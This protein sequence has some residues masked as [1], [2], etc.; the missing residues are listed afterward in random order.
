[1]INQKHIEIMVNKVFDSVKRYEF[2][3]YRKLSDAL[4]AEVFETTE[5]LYSPPENGYKPIKPGEYWGQE[6]GYGWFRLIYTVPE[7]LDGREIY[8]TQDTGAI[9]CLVFIN[10]KCCG[11]FDNTADYPEEQRLH[12]TKLLTKSAKAGET[13]EIVLEA[14]S[15]HLRSGC[16]PFEISESEASRYNREYRG[17]TILELNHTVYD[18]LLN[19]RLV[20]QL[21][22]TLPQDSFQKGKIAGILE[23]VFAVLSQD[24]AA[25]IDSA[26]VL[27]EVD[28]ANEL[29][30]PLLLDKNGDNAAFAGLIGHSHL[31]TVWLWPMEETVHK[32]ARTFS[33][34]LAMME[35]YPEY[36][37]IASSPFHYEWIKNH[38]PEMFERIKQRVA[39]GRWEPNGGS[40]V[41]TDCN[42]TG[43]E[44]LIRQFVK[45]QRFTR[46]NFNYTADTFWLP[47]TFGY[48]ASI[49]QIM[50]GCGMK[51]FVT[52]K[53]Y[54][55]DTVDFPYDTFIWRGVDG[56]EVLS[57][58][59]LIHIWPD[60]FDVKRGVYY[61]S[62]HKK[63]TDRK[64]L[65]Y[66]LGDGG[67]GPCKEMID[68]SR[69]VS[70]LCGMPKTEHT[71][72]SR[73]LNELA[74]SVKDI[75]LY[76]GELYYEY[77]RGTLTSMAKIKYLNRHIEFALRNLEIVSVLS[78]K[79]NGA[80]RPKCIEKLYDK[81]Y[82]NQFHDILPGSSIERVN[83]RAIAEMSEVLEGANRNIS[84]IFA[85]LITESSDITLYNTLSWNRNDVINLDGEICF[86]DVLT[87]TYTDIDGN[88]KTAV[89]GVEIPA[90]SAVTL[91]SGKFVSAENSPFTVNGNTVTTPYAKVEFNSNGEIVSLIDTKSRRELRDKN[92]FPL[93]TFI[94]GEDLPSAWD[95]WNNDADQKLKMRNCVKLISKEIV[96]NGAVELRIRNKY[97]VPYNSTL[98]Q[99]IVFY[100]NSPKIDFETV[101]DWNEKHRLLKTAF[102][103]DLIT[104]YYKSEIQYGYLERASFRD[105]NPYEQARFEVCNHK[106]SDMSESRFGVALLNDSKYGV[107]VDG[108]SMMITL[109][110]SGTHPDTRGDNGVHRF[111]YSLLPHNEGFGAESVIRPAYELNCPAISACGRLTKEIKPLIDIS[112]TNVICEAVK[113]AEDG[114]GI[115]FRLYEAEKSGIR[116]KIKPGFEYKKAYISNMLEDECTEIV[117]S[118]D[119]SFELSFRAFE[120]KTLRFTDK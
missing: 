67:G 44:M 66:G 48:A 34:A 119:G 63:V 55:N 1:M 79:T 101:V 99:D 116:C 64:L 49:P 15:G 82:P 22:E 52:T 81:F 46:E 117:P 92:S 2:F 26:E 17:I 18:F 32:A 102:A 6:W 23:Q 98:T 108:K 100:S 111:T 110:K 38:Y 57:H 5:H 27:Q 69:K 59:S 43:G 114:N 61:F 97:Q 91:K 86:E 4:P 37:F 19:L 50:K 88:I 75:P 30:K 33:N 41:E 113:Y 77:H 47:D 56:S 71:T 95:N 90:F 112:E 94:I 87:Q 10:G 40:W 42:I 9:E 20:K 118:S 93:N 80:E 96:S 14:Y 68:I 12:R 65:A 7:E 39:E 24:P 84:D 70:N 74:E 109:L 8:F 25:H 62:K 89:T 104:S 28:I 73:F 29:I 58:F 85:S 103:F 35:L 21:W 13:F 76:D 51:Y 106:W 120:I 107:C 72:V 16:Q 78:S 83:D 36:T 60:V 11:E 53:L 115:A 3:E 105:N 54:S 45:G 31:D